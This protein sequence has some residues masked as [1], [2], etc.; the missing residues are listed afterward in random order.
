[1]LEECHASEGMNHKRCLGAVC[2]CLVRTTACQVFVWG[3]SSSRCH[4][5]WEPGV[6]GVRVRD[7]AVSIVVV[8]FEKPLFKQMIYCSDF[9]I[10]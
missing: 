10:V 2:V 3:K 4:Q 5:Q 8:P 1:M 9:L 6:E 7:V